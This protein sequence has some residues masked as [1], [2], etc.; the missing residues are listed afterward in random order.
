M[1]RISR[2]AFIG[3]CAAGGAGTALPRERTLAQSAPAAG[4]KFRLSL[5]PGAIGVQG[6]L[7]AVIELAVRHGF[8]AVEPNGRELAAMSDDQILEL[9]AQLKSK[10]LTWGSA[11]LPVDFRQDEA[12]YNEGLDA[13]RR[14]APALQKAGVKRMGTWIMPCHAQLTY[15]QNFQ[16][17]ASR[18]RPVARMLADHGMQLGFEYVGTQLVRNSRKYPFLHTMAEGRELIAEIGTGNLGFVLDS[19]HWWTAGESPADIASLRAADIVSVDINDAPAGLPREQQVDG[20]REL[21]SSTGV[22]PIAQFLQ[23]LVQTGYD[24]PVRSEPF[25]KAVNDLDNDAACA[26]AIAAMKR[27]IERL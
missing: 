18:L 21:P 10:Q 4:R 3:V 15:L 11:G 22:I 5:S 12:K 9:A 26:A 14:Q 1:N 6:S 20:Q 2:R 27:S 19:W 17:H 23:A 24:G 7:A 16:L 13:L 8:E 25:N